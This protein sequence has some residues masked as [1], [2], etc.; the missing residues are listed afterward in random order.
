MGR[1]GVQAQSANSHWDTESSHASP[2]S[3]PAHHNSRLCEAPPPGM[4][5]GARAHKAGETAASADPQAA[6]RFQPRRVRR[7]AGLLPLPAAWQPTGAASPR[8]VRC[9]NPEP[10]SPIHETKPGSERSHTRGT[11]N[12]T[13]VKAARAPHVPR[14]RPLAART[15]PSHLHGALVEAKKRFPGPAQKTNSGTPSS[16][17]A[18]PRTFD[19][20]GL[21]CCCSLHKQACAPCRIPVTVH[22]DKQVRR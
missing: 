8:H 22:L 6:M 1:P 11:D 16:S 18:F 5:H 4:L 14:H 2:L 17:C 3:A 13:R 21:R 7:T 20:T 15:P 12:K 10:A 9:S 19:L